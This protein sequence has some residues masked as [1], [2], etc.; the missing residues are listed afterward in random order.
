M[1]FLLYKSSA[2]S[3]KTYIL[4]KEYI[5]IILKRGNF[6]SVLA[7]TFTNQAAKEMKKRIIIYLKSLASGN[8]DSLYD[9]LRRELN[10]KINIQERSQE[11][12]N[13]ILHNY[14]DFKITT[15]DSFI[16]K[17]VR[18]FT[19]ELEL[20][21]YFEVDLQE[22]FIR[23]KIEDMLLEEAGKDKEI[24]NLL[25]HYLEHEIEKDEIEEE[26]GFKK[27]IKGQN[28]REIIN[29]SISSISNQVFKETNSEYLNEVRK[30]NILES[31]NNRNLTTDLNNM[32]DDAIEILSNEPYKIIKTKPI[33]FLKKFKKDQTLDIDK[34]RDHRLYHKKGEASRFKY[35]WDNK[36]GKPINEIIHFY[37]KN[38]ASFNKGL[39]DLLY[40]SLYQINLIKEFQNILE[41][42][43]KKTNTVPNS[44]LNQRV[45]NII[46]KENTP[47]IYYKIGEKYHNYLIDEFQDTSTLHWGNLL[48]LIDNSLAEGYT[49]VA[50]GDVKQSIYRWRG[51]DVKIMT[52]G[53]ERDLKDYSKDIIKKNLEFNYRSSSNIVKFNNSF[54]KNIVHNID[55]ENLKKIYENVKQKIIK[56]SIGY[57]D[58]KIYPKEIDTPTVKE[59]I[60]HNLI[61]Q[62][63]DLVSKKLSSL[64]DIAIL[65]RNNREGVEIAQALFEANIDVVS[66]ESLLIYKEPIIKLLV[67][68]LK[69]LITPE[70][71]IIRVTFLL[72]YNDVKNIDKSNLFEELESSNLFKKDDLLFDSEELKEFLE[73]RESLL[74]YSLY[75]LIEELIKL[76]NLKSTESRSS[77]FLIRFLDAVIDSK[78]NNI[79]DF[80]DWWENNQSSI[81]LSVPENFDGVRI[82]TIHKSKGLQFPIVFIPFAIWDINI[83]SGYPIWLKN[84]KDKLHY[85]VNPKK[86]LEESFFEESFKEEKEMTLIDNLNLLYVA[87]TRAVDYLFITAYTTENRNTIAKLLYETLF[88]KNSIVEFKN[89]DK[90]LSHIEGKM[91]KIEQKE[92][93]NVEILTQYPISNIEV[94]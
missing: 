58:V 82:L 88:R 75:S 74:E 17:V 59:L 56:D 7:I 20:P 91:E 77:R 32:I 22:N 65:V 30:F 48:P 68:A 35:F 84:K 80:L 12:L 86:E 47:F 63:D 92:K 2:G 62:I 67:Y 87:F 39:S 53:L 9:D 29:K 40:K 79:L 10:N 71:R 70:N 15:I 54:F 89:I 83:K 14:S 69:W 55:N 38:I 61:E 11:L 93:E 85:I 94:F 73:K 60:I 28:I 64:K 49:N 6:G 16:H 45:S 46:N 25:L 8:K 13:S 43:I 24:T 26:K 52:D 42:Y 33:K 66:S 57:V 5:K 1:P 27:D 18:K 19:F 81:S 51:G 31:L 72:L 76:F 21:P 78:T 23:I 50:V 3:G 44:T 4:V 90:K 41:S 37:S 34:L 36:L